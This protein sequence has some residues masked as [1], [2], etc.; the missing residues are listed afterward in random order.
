MSIVTRVA[1]ARESNALAAAAGLWDALDTTKCGHPEIVERF[2]ADLP[3]DAA[4]V[5]VGCWNGAIAELAAL[6]C[7]PWRSYIAVDVVAAAVERFRGLGLPLAQAIEADVRALPLED[8]SADAVLC[9]FVLQDLEGYR[10]DGLRALA[11]LARVARRGAQMLLALTVQAGP[12]EDTHYVVKKLRRLGIPEKPTH[13][14]HGADFLAAVRAAGLRIDE[15]HG[16]GPNDRGFVELYARAVA[17]PG[18][19]PAART[20]PIKLLPGAPTLFIDYVRDFGRVRELF[21]HDY[22][23]TAALARAVAA[24]ASRALP[25]DAIADVLAEQQ[26]TTTAAANVERLRA[27]GSVA[28]VTGQQPALGGGPLYTLYKTA[29][30]VLLAHRVGAVPVFWIANDDH[31]LSA[32][33]VGGES[34]SAHVGRLLSRLFEP[35]GL[36]V[37]DASD[38]RLCRL[39][40]PALAAEL[41]FPSPTAVAAAV[42]AARIAQLGHKLQVPLRSDRLSLF[43]GRPRRFRVRASAAGFQIAHDAEPVTRAE[44]LELY[45]AQPEAFSPNALLRPLYQDALLPTAAYVAGPSEIAY[46]AQ[47]L[48]VYKRFGMQMPVIHPR[49]SVTLIEGAP[50]GLRVA[51][52]FRDVAA[53]GPLSGSP[54]AELAPGGEPQ[55]RVLE[56]S[57]AEDF[58]DELLDRLDLD[59]F[60]HQLI[61][62]G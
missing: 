26:T 42:A 18:P 50:S 41:A 62:R 14:W 30:A 17:H 60:D 28:I 21:A 27:P 45:A 35:H 38:V 36:V 53:L 12:E 1:T 22:R 47:L 16:F 44:L 58:V 24:A 7:A 33:M 4:I 49:K 3:A 40:M 55:E 57:Y 19:A 10:A 39:G 59:D 48:P 15:L 11:E 32:A 8:A 29:T 43:H 13:H 25:R 6:R 37:I 56:V 20:V 2:L 61:A 46:Y 5:D 51:D 34:L 23:D 54:H 31:E 9:L 52:V